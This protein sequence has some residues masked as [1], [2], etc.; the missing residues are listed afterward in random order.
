MDVTLTKTCVAPTTSSRGNWPYQRSQET[1]PSNR[2][3]RRENLPDSVCV[4]VLKK[5]EA[6]L[7][8]SHKNA[9]VAVQRQ[10]GSRSGCDSLV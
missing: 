5:K 7:C 3:T 2:D 9:L 8:A 6:E 4:C 1:R 10:R